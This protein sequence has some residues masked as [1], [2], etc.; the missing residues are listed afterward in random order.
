[1]S[2]HF[3]A[4]ESFQK[5]LK[6]Y[7]RKDLGTPAC[8]R[9][10]QYQSGFL[11]DGPSLCMHPISLLA[12]ASQRLQ[13]TQERL[14]GANSL[15]G[16]DRFR[17]SQ[18]GNHI[19]YKQVFGL[20][21]HQSDGYGTRTAT[22]IQVHSVRVPSA[23]LSSEHPPLLCCTVSIAR[24]KR[25]MPPIYWLPSGSLRCRADN[26]KQPSLATAENRTPSP[27]LSK[28]EVREPVVSLR[29]AMSEQAQANP[30]PGTNYIHEKPN[31]VRSR[32]KPR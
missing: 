3:E 18:H 12:D 8:N 14:I 1:M 24:K 5:V 21:N 29:A 4:L 11:R 15:T 30:L 26:R 32:F 10:R 2:D 22:W 20:N 6:H 7:N 28:L 31:Q 17:L 23:A 19:V 25:D 16:P 9:I 13:G 27:S